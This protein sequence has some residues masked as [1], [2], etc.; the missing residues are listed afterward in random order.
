MRR[1]LIICSLTLLAGVLLGCQSPGADDDLYQVSL[2]DAL[3]AGDYDGQVTIGE[4]RRHGDFGIGT[5]D[6]LD[7]EMIFINGTVY[8]AAADG[9][10]ERVADDETTPFAVVTWFDTDRWV[11]LEAADDLDAL[12]ANLDA[13][14]DNKNLFYALKI[15]A[16]LPVLTIRSVPAQSRPYQALADVVA[17]ESVWTHEDIAG[18]L[19]GVRCPAYTKGLN[20]PGYH[21]HFI[22]HDR[23]I[24]GHVLAATL[25]A[26][27]A[28]VDRL[29]DWS[30]WLPEHGAF[31]EV[32]L[33]A[34]RSEAL[35]EV[36][37]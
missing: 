12:H 2:I 13:A 8:R 32:D 37:K 7:G 4:L 27:R 30:I 16:V 31:S 11:R 26:T 34:D 3:L 15:E 6:R 23:K 9:T 10:V 29:A 18:T 17:D 14:L 25:P 35:D 22:S 21:W 20:V 1:T 24:G 33:E 19:V 36:E 28:R 5:F